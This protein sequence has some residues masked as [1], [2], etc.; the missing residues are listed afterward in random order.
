MSVLVLRCLLNDWVFLKIAEGRRVVRKRT[1]SRVDRTRAERTCARAMG[2]ATT[3]RADTKT[4]RGLGVGVEI[5]WIVGGCLAAH[6]CRHTAKPLITY[7]LDVAL[8]LRTFR[9]LD[10]VVYGRWVEICKH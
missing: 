8:C 9:H 3:S 4:F 10:F 7:A 1:R 2:R 6:L 5:V